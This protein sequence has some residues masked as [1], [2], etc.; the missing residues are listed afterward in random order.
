MGISYKKV[1][2]MKLKQKEIGTFIIL[3]CLVPLALNMIIVLYLYILF[4]IF[5]FF[6]LTH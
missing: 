4:C 3:D 5:M 2:G 1:N 6:V